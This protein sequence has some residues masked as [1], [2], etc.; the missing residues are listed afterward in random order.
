MATQRAQNRWRSKHRF[1]KTQLNVMARTDAHQVLEELAAG[2]GLRGKA[3]AVAFACFVMRALR[4]RA[5][6]DP[7]AAQMLDDFAASYHRD[8]DLYSP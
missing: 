3:E 6:Y 2:F 7:A 8:R 4:Q 5:G 1:V